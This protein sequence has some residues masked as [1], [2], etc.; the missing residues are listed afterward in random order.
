MLDKL[1]KLEKE[2][3]EIQ[4]KLANADVIADQNLYKKMS[5]RYKQLEP[6]AN[7]ANEFREV[8]QS[9]EEAEE[10]LKEGPDADMKELAEAQLSEAKEKLEK[11]G[12]LLHS[13]FTLSEIAE[14]LLELGKINLAQY[15][16][17]ISFITGSNE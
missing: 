1:E 11:A 9:K 3:L 6:A 17:V 10:I 15:Q 7:L 5:R 8:V 2:F 14:V 12:Y 16:N 13:V 4:G